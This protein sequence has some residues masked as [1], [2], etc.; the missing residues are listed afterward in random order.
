RGVP[1]GRKNGGRHAEGSNRPRP[2]LPTPRA[3]ARR[4]GARPA[5]PSLRRA[6]ESGARPHPPQK[7]P[8]G[9]PFAGG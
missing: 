1:D 9:H 3:A 4:A 6:R 7:W 2:G 5:P 8:R